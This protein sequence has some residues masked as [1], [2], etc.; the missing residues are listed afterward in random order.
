MKYK[1]APKSNITKIFDQYGTPL[2]YEAGQKV[3]E[4]GAPADRLWLIKSGT[5]RAYCTNPEGIE[6]TLHFIG[7]GNVIGVESL[8]DG[9]AFLNDGDAVTP[10]DVLVLSSQTCMKVW[11]EKGY[12]F[13]EFFQQF[14]QKIFTLQD[15]IC[16][17]HYRDGNQKVAYFL[18]SQ[19]HQFGPNI[20]YSNDQIAALT[21]INR[22]SVNRILNDFSKEGSIAL[23]YRKVQVIA[24]EKLMKVFH[25]V[26]YL[27]SDF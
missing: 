8:V 13:D 20:S 17:S 3:M 27:I 4:K 24:P 5:I 1:H 16:C 6:I 19:W 23:G 22:V 15:M 14:I 7:P 18:Y 26:G 2:H 11:A 10:M 25:S 12:P 21:G 9:S